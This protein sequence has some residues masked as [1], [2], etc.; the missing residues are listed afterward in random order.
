MNVPAVKD[1]SIAEPRTGEVVEWLGHHPGQHHSLIVSGCVVGA[2]PRGGKALLEPRVWKKGQ[3]TGKIEL[4][5]MFCCLS[6]KE[7]TWFFVFV[8]FF[9]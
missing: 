5:V 2:A 7:D 1:G 3:I 6:W 8:L 9:N 4:W